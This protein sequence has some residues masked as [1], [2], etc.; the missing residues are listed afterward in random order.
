MNRT[1]RNCR[2][3]LWT[4]VTLALLVVAPAGA[5]AENA[6]TRF[7][8]LPP[9]AQVKIA[10]T[11]GKDNPV[12]HAAAVSGGWRLT[13][14]KSGVSAYFATAGARIVSGG[15]DWRLTATAWGRS[16]TLTGLAAVP[17]TAEANR[18]V[19]R[20][21]AVTEWYV[22]SPAG[23]EQGLTLARPPGPA[24]GRPLVVTLA[25]GGS[26]TAVRD[27][28]GLALRRGGSTVLTYRGLT[29][30]DADGRSLPARLESRGAVVALVVD[31]TAARYPVVID[32]YIQQA[33]LT[34]ANGVSDDTF[35]ESVAISGDGNTIVVGATRMGDMMS[36]NSGM[37]YVFVRGSSWATATE[38]A[39]L[40][41]SDSIA[42]NYFGSSV[43]VSENGGVIVV[44]Q[45]RPT[46]SK[47][48]RMSTCGP[49]E[50]GSPPPARPPGLPPQT[51]GQ[52][53]ISAFPWRSAATAG[54]WSRG[55]MAL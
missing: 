30:Y 36:F 49:A 17:P 46:R 25:T 22:N 12:Y 27:G 15:D 3:V 47:G 33:K 44:G 52:Q 53:I 24:D 31:D 21:G 51:A 41:P 34:A 50:G 4:T 19:Y 10:A 23:L 54:P 5:W 43:A 14:P 26:L 37:A 29:A 45:L 20:R 32:P 40:S 18:V 13:T 7:T 9:A 6:R 1:V 48:R 42:M 8:D 16:D 11:L 35:G 38:T 39:R 2:I 28:D 55:R